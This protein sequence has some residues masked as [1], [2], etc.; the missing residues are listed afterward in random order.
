MIVSRTPF[1][2]TLG[3]GGTDLPSFYRKHGGFVLALGIDKYMYVVLNVPNADRMVRLHYTKSEVVEDVRQLQHDLAREALCAHGIHDAIE[4]A[5]VADIPAGTGV[6]SSS[7]YLVGLL[8]CIRTYLQ[9]PVPLQELAEEA[10]RI[11]LD[12]LQQPIGKQDQFMAAFGG[13]TELH[14]GRSGDVTV[15]PVPLPA[16]SVADFIANTQLYYTHV[17]RNAVDILGDQNRA[18]LQGG[19]T[20]EDSLLRIL[21]LGHRISEAIR[22]AD[23]DRFGELMHEHWMAKRMLSSKVTLPRMEDLYDYVREEYGVLGG[24]IAGAGGGGFLMLYCPRGRARLTRFLEAQG[25]QRLHY[26]AEFEGSRIVAN[27]GNTNA[28]HFHA[29]LWAPSTAPG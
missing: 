27:V 15:Q 26:A 11:E 24:K 28:M 9:R 4:I 6:G 16:Y 5:S 17:R 10:C 14:I 12:I 1:R 2:L 22:T 13:L 29:A 3:G 20:V 19:G 25:M 21:D 18:L 7:C 8:N 23:F